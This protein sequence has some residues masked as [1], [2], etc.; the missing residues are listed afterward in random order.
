M[1]SEWSEFAPN[2]VTHFWKKC[3]V[4]TLAF[5]HLFAWFLV[6][7]LVLSCELWMAF[8]LLTHFARVLIVLCCLSIWSTHREHRVIQVYTLG[9]SH[10]A[11][12]ITSTQMMCFQFK[13]SPLRIYD[14]NLPAL[15]NIGS[16]ALTRCPKLFRVSESGIGNQPGQLLHFADGSVPKVVDSIFNTWLPSHSA[17]GHLGQEKEVKRK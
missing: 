12:R 1:I 3:C 4:A 10:K 14:S 8:M 9:A 2:R 15:K 16:A 7:L 17:L 13:Y 6:F 5:S 11:Q